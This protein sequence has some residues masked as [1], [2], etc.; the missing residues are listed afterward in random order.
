M[1]SPESCAMFEQLSNVPFA[2]EETVM[3]RVRTKP[4]ARVDVVDSTR[5]PVQQKFVRGLEQMNASLVERDDENFL[6]LTGMLAQ[7]HVLFV[8]EPGVAKSLVADIAKEFVVGASRRVVH[9]CKDT[10]RAMAF[11]PIDVAAIKDGHQKR[12]LTGGAAD[13]HILVLEE[14]FKAGPAVLDMF[15]LVMNERRYEEGVFSAKVPLKLL[16]GTSNEWSPGRLRGRPRRVLRSLPVPEA[17][18]ARDERGAPR[19]PPQ[20]GRERSVPAG[21]RRLRHA[22]RD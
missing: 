17:R 13:A 8:G 22:R 1:T 19:P 6:A 18:P 12:V 4:Q 20:S 16:I 5:V 11:G 9:C 15:L 21:L 7:E 14:V 10:T 3:G 2:P